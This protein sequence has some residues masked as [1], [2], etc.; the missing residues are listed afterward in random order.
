[1]EIIQLHNSEIYDG[2]TTVT[3]ELMVHR[4][5]VELTKGKRPAMIVFP[6]GGYGFTSDREAEPIASAYFAE[7]YNC[8]TV[9]YICGEKAKIANPLFDAAA[10]IAHVRSNAD[11]YNIDPEKIAVIGFSAGGHL[12]GF[13]ATQWHRKEIAEKLGIDN[14]LCKPNAAILCYP[15]VTQNVPTHCESFN[16]LLG[17]ERSNELNSMANLDENVDER[18]CPCFIWHTASDEAVPVA[19]SLAFARALTDNKIS[20]EMHIFPYGN[21]GLSRANA[22]TAPDW[23]TEE[24]TI[25]YVARW[26]G[27][28]IKWLENTLFDGKFKMT[29]DK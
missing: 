23:G 17:A 28:S 7:G 29:F 26:M 1:M 18:T 14:D 19:N 6:G 24:Y 13:I 10:A 12:A 4:A 20:C 2:A 16:N 8:F 15:V 9:R 11:K 21:H 5:S 25:P 22:E 27:W 3:V